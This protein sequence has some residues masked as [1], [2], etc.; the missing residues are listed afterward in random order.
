MLHIVESRKPRGRVAKDLEEAVEGHDAPRRTVAAVLWRLLQ[1]T[2]QPPL[3]VWIALW[4]AGRSGTKG[5][6]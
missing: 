4:W 2:T 5:T 6:L 3:T 1:M